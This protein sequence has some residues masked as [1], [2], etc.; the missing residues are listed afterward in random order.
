MKANI[1]AVSLVLAFRGMAFAGNQHGIDPMLAPPPMIPPPMPV[2][3]FG[4]SW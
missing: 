2:E 3:L 1:L 4:P